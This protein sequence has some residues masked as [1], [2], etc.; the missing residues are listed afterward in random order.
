MG[1]AIRDWPKFARQMFTFTVPGGFVEVVDNALSKVVVDDDSADQKS[2]VAVYMHKLCDSLK[3]SGINSDLDSGYLEQVLKDAGFVDVKV[4][5]VKMP[6]GAWPK[7]KK[8]K[9]AGRI[10]AEALV[11]GFEAY[12]LATVSGLS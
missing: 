8:F 3:A 6:M 1:V 5:N 7:D 12:G 9:K 10:C 4:T 2:S 11:T